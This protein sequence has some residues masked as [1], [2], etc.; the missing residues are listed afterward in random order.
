MKHFPF[1]NAMQWCVRTPLLA[2]CI[3]MWLVS[4]PAWGQEPD[5]GARRA[6]GVS[7]SIYVFNGRQARHRVTGAF[8][9]VYARPLENS[10]IINNRNRMQGVLPGLFVMQNNGEPGDES[11]SLLMR[12]RRTFRNNS[13]VV[14]VDGYERSMDLLDPNEIETITVLKDAAA[15]ALYGLRGGNGIILVTTNRGREGKIKV[16]LN[17]RAGVKTPT[18]TPK[19]LNSHQY[20]TLYNEALT[21][22]GAA[23]LY[24]AADL[25]KYANAVKGIYETDLDRYLYPNTNWYNEYVNPSTWQQRYSLS[26]D[27]GNKNARYFIS[28]GYTNNSGLYKVDKNA[29]TYNTNADF[30][31]ITL[32]SN[33]DITVNKRLSVSLDIGG[34][35]E[36]RTYPGSR[37]DAAVRVFRSLYKTPPNAFPVFTPDGLL[38]GTKDYKDNPYGLLN[39][40]GYSLYYV[41]SMFATLRAKHELDFIT[42]GLSVTA[43]ASFD[44]WHDQVTN[45]SKSFKVYDL[46]QPDG[47]VAYLP[48]GGIKYVETGSNTQMASEKEYPTTQRVMNTDASLVYERSFGRHS[49]TA[50][51]AIAQRILADE[52]NANI[53][54][55]YLGGNGRVAYAYRNR[56]LAEFNFGYQGSEQFLEGNKF[57]FFP[58]VSLG[59][60]LTE[61]NFLKENKWIN[62]LKLRA[63]QGVTGND[64]LGG[65]F[66]W[67]QKYQQSGTVNFG[68]TSQSY[69]GWQETA[70]ALNNVTWE[71]VKKTNIGIDA[72]LLGNKLNFSFDYFKENN[73]DIMIQPALPNIMGIRFPDFPIGVVENKGFDASIGYTDRIGQLEFSINGVITSAKNTVLDRGEEKQRFEYQARTGRSLDAI[74]GLEAIGLFRDQAEI[75]ASPTQTFGVVK[76]GDIRYKDQNGDKVIDAYD[77]VYLGEGGMPQLQYGAGLGLKYKGFDL[78]VLFTGQQGTLQNMTGEAVWEFHD[79][80]TV[81]E[82]HLGRFNP[83]DPASQANATYPRLSLTNKTNN[84]RTSTYWL[85]KGN[86]VRLRS[87]EIGY[88]LPQGL[89]SKLKMEKIRVYVNGYNLHS[90]SSTDLMDMEARSSHYVIYPIQRIINGGLNVTF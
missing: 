16:S 33:V 48:G 46:R 40:Q 58:A 44:S 80:G 85:K 28:A 56:Y 75:D 69:T 31:M 70:F 13:P 6:S 62:F 86:M 79:N 74:F 59:W 42:K 77:Q 19:L 47:T 17:A 22:D 25:G 90:W 60:V 88:T 11:A 43:S 4:M 72:A 24:S 50:H 67:Y 89:L 82:H 57:G 30:N 36:Q 7:D 12:G 52:N 2:A 53:P 61:E 26:I 29:N 34:R 35:Q 3:G 21:N 68:W 54:N 87:L 23:P 8:S 78:N 64:D 41:R 83:N 45:R 5:T 10:P 55:A 9:Q 73:R 65:Y 81:R 38:G 63:S 15:T 49:V 71:K 66:I 51:A 84:Q 37:T 39:N 1:I 14:M 18:T 27:G 20:A 32:R 76:P